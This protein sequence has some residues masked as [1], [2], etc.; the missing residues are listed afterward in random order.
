MSA[1]IKELIDKLN[2]KE[3]KVRK[4]ALDEI[5]KL[6]ETKVDWIYDYWDV[7]TDKLSSDNSYQRTI[8]MFII[9]NLVISDDK[10]LIDRILDKYLS[11]MEDD[12]FITS[13]QTIQS[14]YKV[15]I[16]KEGTRKKIVGHLIKTFTENKHLN[17]RGNLIRKDVVESLCLIYKYNREDIDINY[18]K[19]LIDKNCDQKEKKLLIEIIEKAI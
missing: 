12:K 16:G 3:N 13:R 11:M 14:S 17:E 4:E 1:N 19:M 2:L 15:A 8:G 10:N 5:L 7:F 18:L 9:S 6:T